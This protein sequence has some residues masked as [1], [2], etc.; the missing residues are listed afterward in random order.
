VYNLVAKYRIKWFGSR[1][2]QVPAAGA[3]R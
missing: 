2:C 1:A 3:K